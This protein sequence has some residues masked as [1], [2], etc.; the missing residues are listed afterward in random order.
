MSS[1]RPRPLGRI[2]F[3]TL[4]SLTAASH[5]IQ[6]FGHVIR[7]NDP[8]LPAFTY[9]S[10]S[11]DPGLPGAV[12]FSQM[13]FPNGQATYPV[14]GFGYYD[15]NAAHKWSAYL[16]TGPLAGYYPTI[17][18]PLRSNPAKYFAIYNV[19]GGKTRVGVGNGSTLAK[20]F[21]VEF[22]HT[23]NTDDVLAT[24]AP[25]DKIMQLMDQ[26]TTL[27]LVSFNA[28]G[29][30]AISRT[31]SSPLLLP[32]V[33]EGQTDPQT[34]MFTSLQD[35]SGHYL[36]VEM[37]PAGAAHTYLV[38]KLDSNGAVSWSRTFTWAAS[39]P[40]FNTIS[41]SPAMMPAPDGSF[42]FTLVESALNMETF[43]YDQKTH[44]IKFAPDGT[45]AWSTTIAGAS[46][47]VNA[48]SPDSASVWLTGNDIEG[49]NPPSI[50]PVVARVSNATGQV[51][52]EYRPPVNEGAGSYATMIAVQADAAYF[53][54]YDDSLKTRSLV[55]KVPAGASPVQAFVRNDTF[56]GGARLSM[57]DTTGTLSSEF[58][59]GLR[60]IG[61]YPTYLSVVAACPDYSAVTVNFKTPELTSQA[62]VITPQATTVTASARTTTLTPI[63][64]PIR[65]LALRTDPYQPTAAPLD[66]RVTTTRNA[67]GHLVLGFQGKAGVKYTLLH[68]PDLVSPFQPIQTLNGTGAAATFT[69]TNLSAGKGFFKISD[70]L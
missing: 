49:L 29:T 48:Y 70:G 45:K 66:L 9:A 4:M 16:E 63:T 18:G 1:S 12:F 22:S 5:G 27:G 37:S 61:Y 10:M 14:T 24:L 35:G 23:A 64:L 30:L 39:S 59:D 41:A 62:L 7:Q 60:V 32:Q 44:L 13:N 56:S 2:A 38:V 33:A 6:P 36:T 54:V 51:S 50:Q 25:G 65:A 8:A 17:A 34:A 67:A 19:P 46:L 40:P 69:I 57:R 15:Q 47:M 43:A 20:D 53:D 11:T 68:S 28:S 55:V 58:G 42:I 52:A 3:T 21:A 31:Y 26:G